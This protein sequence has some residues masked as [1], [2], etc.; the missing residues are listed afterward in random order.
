MN[1]NSKSNKTKVKKFLL[2]TEFLHYGSTVIGYSLPL[3]G[4][5]ISVYTSGQQLSDPQ[6]LVLLLLSFPWLIFSGIIVIVRKEIPRPGLKSVKGGWAVFLGVFIV[7]VFGVSEFFLLYT[8]L[9]GT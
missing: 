1:E 3:L 2:S 5:I 7:F 6:L 8:L 9:K 4:S